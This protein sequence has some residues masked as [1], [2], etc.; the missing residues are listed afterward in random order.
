[1][2]PRY[3]HSRGKVCNNNPFFPLSFS[4]FRLGTIPI[5]IWSG[6][7]ALPGRVNKP[8]FLQKWNGDRYT[9]C[10]KL[11][12]M[13]HFFSFFITFLIITKNWVRRHSVRIGHSVLSRCE[14]S[15]LLSQ[16][17][18]RPAEGSIANPFL[19]APLTTYI[20]DKEGSE[21]WKGERWI[22]KFPKNVDKCYMILLSQI[23]DCLYD[24]KCKKGR[25]WDRIS[26]GTFS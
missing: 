25:V 9:E 15:P 11:C 26:T 2:Q 8:T 12:S 16:G 6:D 21:D 7:I 3:H 1:M 13:S 24:T 18:L 4:K 10:L 23:S 20:A 22:A 5:E 17:T 14:I 19:F